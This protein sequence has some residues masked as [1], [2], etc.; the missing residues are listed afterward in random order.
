VNLAAAR[1]GPGDRLAARAR[2]KPLRTQREELIERVLD[3]QF[4]DV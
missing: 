3:G 2:F 4:L 1:R